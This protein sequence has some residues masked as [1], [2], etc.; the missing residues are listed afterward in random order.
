[1]G[2]ITLLIFF[3]Q[4]TGITLKEF[5]RC[6]TQEKPPQEQVEVIQP[7]TYQGSVLD[8]DTRE[9]IAGTEI[10]FIGYT[11]EVS[12]CQTDDNGFFHIQLP[13]EYQNVKIKITHKDYEPKEFNRKLIG[14]Y[15]ETPDIFYLIPK[16]IPER[17]DSANG[18]G[19]PPP[20]Q[21]TEAVITIIPNSYFIE[22]NESEF[23]KHQKITN[24]LFQ[25]L[26]VVEDKKQAENYVKLNIVKN[27][28]EDELKTRTT[29][30][31][32]TIT[33]INKNGQKEVYTLSSS[34]DNYKYFDVQFRDACEDINR[35]IDSLFK[36]RK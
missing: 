34:Q 8:N 25:V 3:Q 5:L 9:Y 31:D 15:I 4:I 29:M 28:S 30:L 1:M 24:K 16:A 36:E 10:A 22:S 2:F 33:V 35:Q 7:I 11:N 21:K 13:K 27:T 6:K 32:A 14:D 19:D 12:T 17:R 18:G 26:N 20:P 23:S